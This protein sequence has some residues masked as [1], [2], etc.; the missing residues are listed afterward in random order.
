MKFLSIYPCKIVVEQ[1]VGESYIGTFTFNVE[2]YGLL[3]HEETCKVQFVPSLKWDTGWA[4]E[5]GSM[6][7]V[8]TPHFAKFTEALNHYVF[9]VLKF[10]PHLFSADEKQV[11]KEV[12]FEDVLFDLSSDSNRLKKVK[13]PAST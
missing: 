5:L 13:K 11:T 7:F 3:M 9:T 6:M 10:V 12:F 2:Q 8:D 1:G 4:L